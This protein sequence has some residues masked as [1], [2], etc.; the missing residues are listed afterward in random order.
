MLFSGNLGICNIALGDSGSYLNLLL[1]QDFL[2]SVVVGK[3]ST[4][5]LLPGVDRSLN[6]PWAFFDSL[7]V[8]GSLLL[9]AE[10]EI[11]DSGSP[12]DLLLLL[13]FVLF[14]RDAPV[15]HGSPR[16]GVELELQLPAYTIATAVWDQSCICKLHHSHSSVEGI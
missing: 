5:L 7:S 6:S 11:Q 15:A 3:W 9:L 1:Q 8:R 2:D 4:A 13:C 14:F 12:L 16:L 10:A